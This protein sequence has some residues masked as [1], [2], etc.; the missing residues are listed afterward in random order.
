VLHASDVVTSSFAAGVETA[1]LTEAML[2][3]MLLSPCVHHQDLMVCHAVAYAAA[4]V[5]T[6]GLTMPLQRWQ[7]A[8]AAAAVPHVAAAAAGLGVSALHSSHVSSGT[9][10]Q[11][12]GDH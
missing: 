1:E 6:A 7:L 5:E 10:L 3:L 11:Q 9:G 2:L 12:V 4:G 8:A